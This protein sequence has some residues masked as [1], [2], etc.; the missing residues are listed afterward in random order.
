M[1][2]T[3]EDHVAIILEHLEHLDDLK[4]DLEAGAMVVV[5]DDRIRVP[6]LPL[7]HDT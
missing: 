5:N 3:A 1:T 2:L 7:L 4:A 6:L